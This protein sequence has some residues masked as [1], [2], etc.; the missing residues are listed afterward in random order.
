[1]RALRRHGSH[2]GRATVL[3]RRNVSNSE[4][5]SPYATRRSRTTALPNDGS[6][7]REFFIADS[8]ATGDGPSGIGVRGIKF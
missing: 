4:G 7:M 1:M 2:I 8:G 6:V 5:Y 3:G